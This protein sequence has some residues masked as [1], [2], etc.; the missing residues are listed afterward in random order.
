MIVDKDYDSLCKR[1]FHHNPEAFLKLFEQDAIFLR[2]LPEGLES[3]KKPGEP[4]EEA[5]SVDCL[6][7]AQIK[8]VELL[9]NIEWQTHWEMRG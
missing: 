7:W 8:A 9:V 4:Q 6:V 5:Q 2:L 1:L 3:A